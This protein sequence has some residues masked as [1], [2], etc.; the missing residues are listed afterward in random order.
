M[1]HH[2]FFGAGASLATGFVRAV[3][4]ALN[5][6]WGVQQELAELWRCDEV[7]CVGFL[8]AVSPV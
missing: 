8:Q 1:D 6:L 5:N 2:E 7:D 3:S 4:A